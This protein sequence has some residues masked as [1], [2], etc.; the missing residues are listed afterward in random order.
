MTEDNC[1]DPERYKKLGE[2]GQKDPIPKIL[3]IQ[4]HPIFVALRNMLY[5]LYLLFEAIIMSLR[6]SAVSLMKP[7]SQAVVRS[8]TLAHSSRY[9]RKVDYY[10]NPSPDKKFRD[11]DCLLEQRECHRRAFEYLSK[12]V[13]I[14]EENEG[15]LL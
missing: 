8:K 2:Q 9:E 11:T 3:V 13:K 12:A 1:L 14:D 6:N 7:N 5:N 15:N 10:M 4:T